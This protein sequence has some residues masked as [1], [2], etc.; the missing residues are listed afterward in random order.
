[1][2]RVAIAS[3]IK[4]IFEAP[5]KMSHLYAQDETDGIHDIRFARAVGGPTI[6][7]N[8]RKGPMLTAPP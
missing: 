5:S 1:M 6:A 8:E 4:E 3:V 2:R 7:A